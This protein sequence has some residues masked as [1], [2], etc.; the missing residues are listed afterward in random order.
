MWSL[1]MSRS[2]FR[3][4]AEAGNVYP[5]QEHWEQ[6]HRL[7]SSVMSRSYYTVRELQQ[8]LFIPSRNIGSRSMRCGLRL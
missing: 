8:E 3:E 5:E 1:I 7:W 2:Y 4:R 6:E